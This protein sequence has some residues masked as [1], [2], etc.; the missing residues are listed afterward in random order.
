M[1]V[2]KKDTLRKNAQTKAKGKA[3]TKERKKAKAKE[4]INLVKKEK[5]KDRKEDA[6]NA[7][8]HITKWTV[9]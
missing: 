4:P 9:L 5:A 3:S 8:V 1:N 7:E 2:V 6:S